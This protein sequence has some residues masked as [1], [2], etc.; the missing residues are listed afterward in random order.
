M[1]V[2]MS[3]PS[4][5]RH[6]RTILRLNPSPPRWPVAV[7]AAVAMAVPLSVGQLAGHLSLG[8]VASLGV[9]TILYGATAPGRFRARVM[10][11]A[12]LGL[13]GAVAL[14][15]MT[16]GHPVVTVAVLVVVAMVAAFVCVALKVGPPGSY[17]FVL[18]LGVGNLAVTHGAAPWS[19]VALTFAGAVSAWVIGMA[20]LLVAPHR[21]EQRATEAAE[22]AIRAFAAGVP[23]DPADPAPEPGKDDDGDLEALRASA[24]GAL[25]RA[26]TAVTDGGRPP[27][28]VERLER[29]QL[30][31]AAASARLAGARLGVEP[32]PWGSVDDEAADHDVRSGEQEPLVDAAVDAEQL[33]DTA[34]GRPGAGY[35][36]RE[37]ARWPSEVL[38]MV[39]RVG[40][41]TT[42]AGLVAHVLHQGHVYWAVCFAA[43]VLHQ[44]GTR[45]VQT[46]RGVHRTL[47]T[48]VGLLIFAG[49]LALDPQGWWLVV[50]VAG[51]QLV[52]ELLI[53]SNYALAVVVITPLALTIGMASAPGEPVSSVVADRLV[54]TLVGVAC[55]LLVLWAT[56]RRAPEVVLRAH[57]RRV[58][59]AT[60]RVMVDLAAGALETRDALDHRR[61]L[62]YELLESDVVARRALAD[63]RDAVGPYHRMERSLAALGY[64]VLGACWHPDIRRAHAA[65]D[66]ARGPLER[67]MADPV[68]TPRPAE[69]IERD[70]REVEELVLS[71][72]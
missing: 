9:F 24:S 15:A 70:V 72:R 51:M 59:V 23:Q 27:R 44:G 35:L 34:L 26:W 31:Y 58:V 65:F 64:L 16:A 19:V 55:A 41:A 56:G 30:T 21:A 22:G 11:L 36:L 54:D 5:R 20:D 48:L 47:G 25:H 10:A 62:Y 12:A 57:A 49:L 38:L 1:M 66:R 6:T 37:A 71:L 18:V 52:V 17:F 4:L 40:L 60:E 2:A 39:L 33:R 50:V 7:K 13:T 29:A 3:S 43:L 69:A 32:R 68:T 46:V 63:S 67:I 53:T 45:E 8:L 14:G 42:F 61:N 28:L